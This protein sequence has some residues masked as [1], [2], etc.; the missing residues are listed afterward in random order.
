MVISN[1]VREFSTILKNQQLETT[2]LS[3]FSDATIHMFERYSI[4]RRLDASSTPTC[5][6]GR[7]KTRK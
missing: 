7:L 1:L 2:R 4:P 3:I 6:L 5:R